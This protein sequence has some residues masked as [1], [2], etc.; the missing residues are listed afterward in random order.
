[1]AIGRTIGCG[2]VSQDAKI[3]RD[4]AWKAGNGQGKTLVVLG[5]SKSSSVGLTDLIGVFM[6]KNYIRFI[7]SSYNTLFHVPDGGSIKIHSAWDNRDTVLPC[8]YV[9]DYH[10]EISGNCYHICQFA[11]MMERNGNTYSPVTEIG[12]LSFY[13]RKYYDHDNLDQNHKIIPYYNLICQ[14][15]YEDPARTETS[16]AYCLE[17][18]EPGKAFCKFVFPTRRPEGLQIQFAATIEAVCDDPKICDRVNHIVAAIQDE[19]QK[20]IPALDDVIHACGNQVVSDGYKSQPI[21]M[22]RG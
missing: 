11:E 18:R 9:D 2:R 8:K 10:V 17:P 5:N 12:D 4:C 1:M 20:A 21:N 19:L 22:E 7:D 16:Y 13:V 15:D 14:K 6:E 3:G